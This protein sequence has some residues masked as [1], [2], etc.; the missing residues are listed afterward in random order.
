[1]ATLYVITGMP[2]SGKTT[3]SRRLAL[4]HNAIRFEPDA[5]LKALDVSAEPAGLRQRVEGLQFRLTKDLLLLGVS[6]I[7]ENGFWLRRERQELLEVARELG[8]AV[9]LHVMDVPI[10][11]RWGRIQKRHS[12]ASPGFITREKLESWERHWEPPS[13]AELA[14][15]DSA[16]VHH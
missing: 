9:E 3:L 8:V 4:E 13:D 6:V 10:E 15:F 5:W 2:G 16:Q 7:V 14:A 11:E 1:M 12:D